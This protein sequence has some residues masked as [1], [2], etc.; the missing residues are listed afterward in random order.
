MTRQ[1]ELADDIADDIFVWS[2]GGGV[3]QLFRL[4]NPLRTS[5]GLH[6]IASH[7]KA[8]QLTWNIE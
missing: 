7:P 8:D 2:G 6:T 5:A 3:V 4:F 1:P